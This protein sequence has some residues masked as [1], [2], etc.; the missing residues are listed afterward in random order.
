MFQYLGVFLK[1]TTIKPHLTTAPVSIPAL[2]LILPTS[3]WEWG[4]VEGSS[5]FT[6]ETQ[7]SPRLAHCCSGLT[8]KV[9]GKVPLILNSG[10]ESLGIESSRWR[11]EMDLE[12]HI[13][14][15]TNTQEI[16]T[17]N[18]LSILLICATSPAETVF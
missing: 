4:P 13:S 18:F 16:G 17:H 9:T 14:Y 8:A 12:P 6:L 2:S 10:S 1:F 11:T 7:W 3:V 15:Q 5:L